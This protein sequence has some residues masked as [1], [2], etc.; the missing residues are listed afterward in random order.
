MAA[1][2]PSNDCDRRITVAAY[3]AI[4]DETLAF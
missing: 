4:V 2:A 1:T 3:C